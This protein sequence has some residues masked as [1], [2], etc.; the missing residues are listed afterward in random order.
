MQQFASLVSTEY[1]GA[2]RPVLKEEGDIL[3]LFPQ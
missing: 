1:M 3:V 2:E